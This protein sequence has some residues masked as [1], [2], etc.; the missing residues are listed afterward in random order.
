MHAHDDFVSVNVYMSLHERNWLGQDIIASTNQINIEDLVVSH[1]TE[2][3][4][5]VIRGCLWCKGDNDTSLRFGI[6]GSLD[7]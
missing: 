1:H 5:V 3:S 2:D 4:L 6:N 7:L